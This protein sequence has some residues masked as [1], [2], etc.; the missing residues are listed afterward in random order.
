VFPHT[1]DNQLTD[2]GKI[3]NL[4]H[5]PPFTPRK[6]PDS[7]SCSMLSRS[8]DHIATRKIRITEKSVTSLGI[9]LATFRLVV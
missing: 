4:T 5:R 9:E 3:V 7:R 2:G 1:L 8:Q 6:I